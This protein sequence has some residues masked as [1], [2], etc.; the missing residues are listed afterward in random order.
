MGKRN[1]LKSG[2][3]AQQL[4][5]ATMLFQGKSREEITKTLFDCL[6]PDRVT[7]DDAKIRANKKKLNSWIANPKFQE[8]YRRLVNNFALQAYG[9]ALNKIAEQMDDK[10][11]WLSNKA[12]NDILTRMTPLVM[13]N[14]QNTVNIR[15][16]GMPILGSPENEGDGG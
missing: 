9:K 4:A 8:H 6:T 14:E 1:F 12:A 5:A 2:L 11:G 10:Q 15:I 7:Y 16:E 3:T 13:G